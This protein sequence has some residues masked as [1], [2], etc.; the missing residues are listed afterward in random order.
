MKRH[1]EIGAFSLVELVVALGIMAFGLVALIG[2]FSV[3]LKVGRDS[4]N[5]VQATS[6]ASK[7]IAVRA[8]SLT[9]DPSGSLPITL[10]E[11]TGSYAAIAYTSPYVDLNGNLVASGSAA[12]RITCSSGTN[13]LTGSDKAQIYLMLSRPPYV[14]P[15]RAE[16]KYEITTFISLR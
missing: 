13:S 9:T 1:T 5:Q 2:L 16:G 8:A 12:Y 4:F 14:T 3:G 15:D 10:A 6:L 7:I 11:L